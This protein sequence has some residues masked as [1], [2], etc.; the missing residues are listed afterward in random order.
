MVLPALSKS[1]ALGFRQKF[2]GGGGGGAGWGNRSGT[3]VQQSDA[4]KM[5]SS[6]PKKIIGLKLDFSC[7]DWLPVTTCVRDG[8]DSNR[9]VEL[10]LRNQTSGPGQQRGARLSGHHHPQNQVRTS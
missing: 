4:L 8:S 5:K 6:L 10:Q 7:D 1:L 3:A 9:Q 2:S